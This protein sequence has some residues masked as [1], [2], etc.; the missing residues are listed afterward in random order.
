MWGTDRQPKN[1]MP[2]ARIRSKGHREI[3]TCGLIYMTVQ[4]LIISNLRSSMFK[5]RNLYSLRWRKLKPEMFTV[6]CGDD[7]HTWIHRN[8]QLYTLV[9]ES[10]FKEARHLCATDSLG[11]RTMGH[12]F[13]LNWTNRRRHFKKA[14][15]QVLR[16]CLSL[17]FL[18]FVGLFS[19][20]MTTIYSSVYRPTEVKH[21]EGQTW[22]GNLKRTE[23]LLIVC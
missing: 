9:P 4:A 10:R 14:G 13:I 12:A 23:T 7:R 1:I 18:Q 8:V 16:F 19:Q 15:S 5:N 17:C 21:R 3:Y 6:C 11:P 2:A 22:K 20:L